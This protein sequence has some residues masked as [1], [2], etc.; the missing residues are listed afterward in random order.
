MRKLISTEADCQLSYSLFILL[1]LVI[2]FIPMF[3][4]FRK[5]QF[6]IFVLFFIFSIF[7][8][9]CIILFLQYLFRDKTND[10]YKYIKENY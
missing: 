5:D 2:F 7:L 6:C 10:K 3:I 1:I 8:I 9:I 4:Y